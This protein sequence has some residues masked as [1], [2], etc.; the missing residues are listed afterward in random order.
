M[1]RNQ[2]YSSNVPDAGKLIDDD[3]CDLTDSRVDSGFISSG[4][5][6]LSG[7]ISEE[8]PE[9]HPDPFRQYR[10]TD[11]SSQCDSGIIED[12]KSEPMLIDSGI[13]LT[14][15][16]P[17]V[18]KQLSSQLSSLKLQNDLNNPKTSQPPVESIRKSDVPWDIYFE[19]DEDG[20]T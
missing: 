13:C 17:T 7:E 1:S 19:Q 3:K 16:E 12:T 5:L 6:L 2:Q 20:D 9:P 10:K 11:L 14:K 15:D 4:S 18:D 8:A